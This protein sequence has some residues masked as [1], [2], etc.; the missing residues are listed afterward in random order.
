MSIFSK[1]T[2]G[3]GEDTL[4]FND[5][6]AAIYFRMQREDPRNFSIRNYDTPLPQ[7]SG[8]ID[9][10]TLIGRADIML[11]GTMYP[12]DEQQYD[13]GRKLLRKVSSPDFWQSHPDSDEGYIPYTYDEGGKSYQIFVKPLYVY[14]PKTSQSGIKQPFQIFTKVKYPVVFSAITKIFGN[15]GVPAIIS[16]AAKY[17]LKYPVGFGAATYS[18][19]STANN[20]GDIEAYPRGITVTGPI[21]S[22]RITNTLT[23]EYIEVA[24]NLPT[25]SDTLSIVYDQDDIHILLNGVS[26]YGSLT[27]TSTLFKLRTGSQDITLSGSSISTGAR[28]TGT[29]ADAYPLA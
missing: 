25:L 19:T 26:V 17:P 27:A 12:N 20:E 29:Y 23:S 7:E 18:V 13:L 10:R 22:P 1:A 2:L 4:T 11:T 5:D 28:I 15:Y 16:G 6:T 21:N 14:L 3:I 24:V 8:M 9:F